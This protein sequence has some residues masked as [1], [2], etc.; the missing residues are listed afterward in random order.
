LN[1]LNLKIINFLEIINKMNFRTVSTNTLIYAILVS[2]QISGETVNQ[3]FWS[4]K[5]TNKEGANYRLE[6]D[7]LIEVLNFAPQTFE[8]ITSKS[9]LAMPTFS[10]EKTY[11]KFYKNSVMHPNLVKRYPNISTFV[12]VGI[13]NPTHRATIVLNENIIIGSVEHE[14]GTSHFKSFDIYSENNE[15]LVYNEAKNY[16]DLVCKPF[17]DHVN[18]TRDF[19]E[20]LGTDDP[21]YPAGVE[22]VTYRFAAMITESVN[23]SAADGTVEGGLTWLVGSV[24]YVNALYVR[25][26]TFQLEIVENNDELIFTDNNPA[27][28]VFNQDCGGPWETL[29]CE[30]GVVDS[31]LDSRIG[32]GGWDAEDE[33]R[34]WDYGA[35][36][37]NGHPGGLAYCP[38][39]TSAQV[40]D[41]WVF[42]HEVMHNFGSPHN[43]CGE[44]GIRTSIGGT[45]MA[46]RVNE[47]FNMFSTHS[48]E[49]ALNYQETVG[50]Y[51]NWWYHNGYT[52]ELTDNTIPQ[53]LLPE[54]GF[55]I[56]SETPYVLEGSSEPMDESFTYNWESNESAN[57]PYSADPNSTEFPFLLPDQGS[58]SVPVTPHPNG[59]KRVFPEMEVL[60]D[61]EYEKYGIDPYTGINQIVEKLPFATREMNM[62]LV[63]RTNDP[64]AGTLNHKNLNFYVDGTAGPFRITSQSDSTIWEVGSD[65]TITWDVANTD[66]PN[67]VNC[68][69]VDILL[70]LNGDGN[71]D[72]IIAESVPNTGSYTFTISPTIPTDSARLM[73]RASDNIFFDINNGKINIQNANIPSIS[74]SDEMIELS[75][76][77]DS[78]STISIGITNNG[79]EGSVLSYQSYTGTDFQFDVG[80]DDGNLPDDWSTS[81]NA[82]C[83]N[84]GW[85]ISEDASS[86]YFTIPPGD[87]YY[88]ATNDDA[89]GSSSDGSNDMLFTGPIQLPDAHI[90]LSFLRYF[91]A[92]F[93]QSFHVLISTDNWETSTELLNLGYWEGNDEEWL[94][95]TINLNAYAGDVVDIAFHSNDNGNWASGLALDDIRLGVIPTWINSDGS[96]YVNYMETSQIDISI[97][98]N[99][100]EP[101]YYESKVVVQSMTTDEKDTV[102]LQLTVEDALV[103]LGQS[104]IPL[105]F[106]LSQNYPN[107]FNPNTTLDYSLP[108]AGSV[109]LAVY[110]LLGHEIVILVDGY[111]EPGYK[112]ITWNGTDKFGNDVSTG[113]YFYKLRSADFEKVKKMVLL[114]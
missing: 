46:H 51:G 85:F 50:P 48:T 112:S 67:G 90:S 21:C 12:G 30:L 6:F 27:P 96:G 86:S 1:Q 68:Q 20:C 15:L 13:E 40:P 54:G 93:S 60:L 69:A 31:V 35:L 52:E 9:I 107:P 99:G 80:F 58:L 37:D 63:V 110:D 111:Q 75:L 36:F 45:I 24:A 78:L 47:T 64:Y 44:G 10:G 26:V 4:F 114:K 89:C 5:E 88:I 70:S 61:N 73:I 100:M 38:G 102:D 79:E 29:G 84:P 23:N 113:M 53:I 59:Y 34:V 43:Y 2:S 62:R 77:N 19:P 11:F 18:Q 109:H 81:T 7:N 95:E 28:D 16:Q 101:G 87:G 105:V 71:F 55:T 82:E 57:E 108:I 76:P 22:L 103:G 66:D 25:D 97:N 106:S 56:P 3:D 92:G 49:Y 65:E 8:R 33:V 104:A 94:Q 83:D 91:S 41:M 17:N 74:L 72:F 42:S 32:P 98:A 14:S 39:P